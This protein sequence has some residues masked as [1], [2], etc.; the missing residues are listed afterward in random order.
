MIKDHRGD[1]FQSEMQM[2]RAW[3]IDYQLFCQRRQRGWSIQTS[4]LTPNCQGTTVFDHEGNVFATELDMCKAYGIASVT[5]K[6]R[7]RRGWNLQEALTIEPMLSDDKSKVT[8]IIEKYNPEDILRAIEL[9]RENYGELRPRKKTHRKYSTGPAKARV[10]DHKG[11]GFRDK[12]EM[13]TFWKCDY[14]LFHSRDMIGWPYCYALTYPKYGP[15]SFTDHNGNSFRSIAKMC[16][17]YDLDKNIFKERMDD[18]WTLK[19][20]LTLPT[21]PPFCTPQDTIM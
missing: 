4:L 19:D 10:Y 15:Y 3:G 20:A 9:F 2:C 1:T 12:K 11:H 18:G 5:Y 13:C 7:R 16:N 21:E 8:E 17:Y 6:Q 14:R